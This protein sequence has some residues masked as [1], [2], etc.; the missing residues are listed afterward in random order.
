MNNIILIGMPGVG[1]TFL[2][3]YLSTK[4]NIAFYDTDEIII[5]KYNSSLPDLIK[6]NSWEWFRNEEYIILNNLLKNNS[7]IIISTGGGIIENN[8]VHNL[9]IKNHVIYIQ[10]NV[11]QEIKISRKLSDTYDILHEKRKPIYEKLANFKYQNESTSDNFYNF[12]IQNI[13]HF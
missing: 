10:K 1:K 3:K 12:V 7:K 5:Q 4:L 11:S 6:I 8:L 2:G 9:L 13:I